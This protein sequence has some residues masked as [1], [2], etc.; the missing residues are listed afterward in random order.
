MVILTLLVRFLQADSVFY[1]IFF[2]VYCV[3]VCTGTIY[4]YCLLVV[5]LNELY[6][7]MLI[8]KDASTI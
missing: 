8:N 2:Y 7:F 3:C 6:S 4:I 5:I 1:A